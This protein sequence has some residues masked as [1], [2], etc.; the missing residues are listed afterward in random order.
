MNEPK[1]PVRSF[2]RSLLCLVMA[3]VTS[4][5]VA[6]ESWMYPVKSP[7]AS[8]S[9]E[10]NNVK[11]ASH[12]SRIIKVH[13]AS[14]DDILKWYSGKTGSVAVYEELAKYMKREPADADESHGSATHKGNSPRPTIVTYA[15]T[16]NRKH[17]TIFHSADDGG[18][19][20][21]SLVGT[22]K[23]TSIQ[24]IQRHTPAVGKN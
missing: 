8:G 15:F 21:I 5:V 9:L 23:D 11:T 20:V 17:A 22:A 7:G 24:I 18:I 16:P 1:I 10:S 12:A 13:F 4:P 2:V 3:F 6:E 14:F 19:V